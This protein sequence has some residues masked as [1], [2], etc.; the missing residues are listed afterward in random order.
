VTLNATVLAFAAGISLATSVLFGLAPAIHAASATALASLRSGQRLDG[1]GA[2]AR[3]FRL[4]LVVAEVALSV[5]LLVGAGLLTRSLANLYRGDP[6][7]RAEGLVR[8]DLE[9]PR[10]KYEGVEAREA[11]AATIRAALEAVPGAGGVAGSGGAPPRSGIYF[12]ALEVEGREGPEEASTILHGNDAGP[13]YFEVLG[14]PV[15]DGRGFTEEETR[16]GANV[17][18]VGRSTAAKYWAPGG[19][20]GSRIRLSED[21]PWSTVVGVV[22]D[23]AVTGLGDRDKLQVYT[24]ARPANVT[25]WLIRSERATGAVVAAARDAVHGV[26]LDLGVT[27]LP[28]TE[29]L[30]A[31][32][33]RQRFIMILLISF[34]AVAM[35]LA[36]VGFYGVL[37]H[38]VA[39]RRR[40]IGIRMSLG[41][42]RRNVLGMVIRQGSAACA[43]GLLAGLPAAFAGTRVVASQL[44]GIGRGDVVTYVL[45]A[46]L[47]LGTS[48]LAS[49]LPAR[50][51]AGVDPMVAI[52]EE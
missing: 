26:D 12:G 24:P 40:E 39:Q 6:G 47:L 22:E 31:S 8:V 25:T 51:A 29:D 45:A 15:L 44:H 2:G 36:A 16:T 33:G 11:L 28:V 20:V 34:A 46:L 1:G 48:A 7:F 32:V 52:R 37:S 5:I 4:G 49:W 14:Q 18:V 23:V 10:W 13:G 43:L 21:Q 27:S 35:A 30:R 38:L 17:F 3:R 50:R 9:L 42:D 41:A 19:A